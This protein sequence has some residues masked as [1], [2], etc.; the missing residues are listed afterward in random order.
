MV[1]AYDPNLYL[2]N[3]IA[4]KYDVSP[5]LKNAFYELMSSKMSTLISP[6]TNDEKCFTEI[7]LR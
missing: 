6:A 3:V 5:R 4:F 2:S 7:K 1:I